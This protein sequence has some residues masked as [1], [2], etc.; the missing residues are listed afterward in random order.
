VYRR[1]VTAILVE[2]TDSEGR[3]GWGEACV[4]GSA[5]AVYGALDSMKPFVLGATPSKRDT[6]RHRVFTRGLWDYQ[7]VTGNYA[8]AAFDMALLDLEGQAREE[9]AWAL[10]GSLERTTVEYFY[11]LSRG[12]DDWL[13][14]Q[15]ATILSQGYKVAYLKVG[16]DRTEE[17]RL[18]G[19][20]RSALGP[21]IAIRIDANG[22]WSPEESV[23][24]L[25][26]WHTEFGIDLCE[27]P[28]APYPSAA[29]QFVRK[30]APTRLAANEGMGPKDNADRLMRDD[31][32]DVYTFSPYWVGGFSHFLELAD[33][34]ASFNRLT[35]RHTHGELGIAST[36]FQHAALVA[37]GLDHGNQ[38]TSAEL[39][40]DILVN[41]LPIRTGP[42]W[43]VISEAG[44]GLHIDHD[45]LE[46][47]VTHYR[48]HGQF[49]PFDPRA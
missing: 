13:L 48:Q 15:C 16:I 11:Y 3:T 30:N 24:I 49:L 12:S 33:L 20:L 44:L 2:L 29:M 35:C 21:Q 45:S 39:E 36:A 7:P 8:W 46:R 31:V 23:A 18:L 4:G 43:G 9:P 6:V 40:Y 38:Q 10:L 19:L 32:A 41:P 25:R 5:E 42:S 27:Q 14:D 17:T 47:A 37:K 34:A 1:G 28:T 26:H 22:A